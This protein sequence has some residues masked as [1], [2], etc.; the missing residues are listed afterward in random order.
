M[1]SKS[2][3]GANDDRIQHHLALGGR[4]FVN[5]EGFRS[6]VTEGKPPADGL[7][8]RAR[9]SNA[10][11]QTVKFL[12][13]NAVCSHVCM[14][15]FIHTHLYGKKQARL[16]RLRVTMERSRHISRQESLGF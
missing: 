13:R 7:S 8:V 1:V 6:H 11:L 10:H 2:E 15:A 3:E 16:L 14:Y 9:S 4:K 5:Q 12:L